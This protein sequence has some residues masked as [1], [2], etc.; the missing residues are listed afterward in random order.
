MV[1]RGGRPAAASW[2]WLRSCQG[3]KMSYQP[4]TMK[5]GAVTSGTEAVCD[6]WVQYSSV[7]RSWPTQS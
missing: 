2:A 3:R 5:T 1:S 7:S 4:V 6:C